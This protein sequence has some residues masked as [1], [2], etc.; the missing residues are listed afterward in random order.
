MITLL[1]WTGGSSTVAGKHEA[2]SWMM[3]R[4]SEYSEVSMSRACGGNDRRFSMCTSRVKFLR[5]G[6]GGEKSRKLLDEQTTDGKGIHTHIPSS[7]GS[8]RTNPLLW[9]ASMAS[10]T[11]H[12]K[13]FTRAYR[14]IRASSRECSFGQDIR[15]GNVVVTYPFGR[16][17]PAPVHCRSW[18]LA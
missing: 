3:T 14:G 15:E 5:F 1:G 7:R 2:L 17:T 4:P 8:P 13:A 11:V 6:G 16:R 9:K 18:R 10:S 12:F